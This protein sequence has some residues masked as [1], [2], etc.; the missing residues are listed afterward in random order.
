MRVLPTLI[1][2]LL[3][4]FCNEIEDCQL[5]PYTDVVVVGFKGIE[6]VAF[7]SIVV[8][9]IGRLGND[10]DTITAMGFPLNPEQ[11][12]T[13]CYFYTDSADYE[14]NVIY[15]TEAL[16]YELNCDVAIRFYDLDFT[17]NF[18]SVRLISPEL[19]LDFFKTN[20]EVIF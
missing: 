9:G 1:L 19:N 6:I 5:D 17:T 12:S 7:D 20:V 8:E 16:I 18:D 3:F 11:L 15:K 13:R 10:T 4:T 14:L 2:V